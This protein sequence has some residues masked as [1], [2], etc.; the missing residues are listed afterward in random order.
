MADIGVDEVRKAVRHGTMGVDWQGRIDFTQL[1]EGRFAKAT[2]RLKEEGVAAIICTLS[3]NKRY[4][5]SCR[6]GTNTGGPEESFAIIFTDSP[7]SEAIVYEF[8][9]TWL[10]E[11]EHITWIKP[12]NYRP[13]AS[14]WFHSKGKPYLVHH[15]KETAEMF[16]RDLAAKGVEKEKIALDAASGL[17]RTAY[18]DVGLNLVDGFHIMQEVRSVKTPEE[19][20]CLKI[21][22][23]VA[24]IGYGSIM[25]NL[26]PGVRNSDIQAAG[27][28]AMARA[29]YMIEPHMVVSVR[30][31][32]ETAPNYIL[33]MPS[34]RIIQPGDLVYTD[35][36]GVAYNGYRTC[37]YRTFKVGT[38][39]T[40]QE[41]DW[42]KKCREILY[43]AVDVLRDGVTTADVAKK[44]PPYTAWDIPNEACAVGNAMGHGIGLSQYDMPFIA[45]ENSIDFPQDIKTG[46]ILAMETWWGQN[47]IV[48][49]WRGGCRIE[50]TWVVTE[51]GHENLYAMPD[52]EILCPAHA[53]YC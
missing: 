37:Y 34:D 4:L 12:E 7:L 38:K 1:R 3:E 10:A 31:G 19:I 8:G 18:E 22:G 21:A 52:T 2:A 6:S 35:V 24:D 29:G 30:S 16:K 51:K 13:F 9:S 28:D 23:A 47:D 32:P 11:K 41:K 25:Q 44:W 45:R 53:I 50:N 48:N 40:E 20:E 43:D 33:R 14:P 5:T 36:A 42:Y 26:R 15:A 17:Q 46:M 27:W 49:G 39:P